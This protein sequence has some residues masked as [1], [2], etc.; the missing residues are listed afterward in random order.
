MDKKTFVFGLIIIIALVAMVFYYNNKNENLADQ[1]AS[2]LESVNLEKEL[3]NEFFLGSPEAPVTMVEYYSHLCGH[4]SSFNSETLPLIIEKYVK[5]GQVRI[6]PRP[7]SPYQLSLA[8]ICAQEQG[9]FFEFND[10]L[11]EKVS[12]IN[13]ID[14]IKEMA[15]QLGLNQENFDQCYDEE[16][17]AQEA[18]DWF[19]KAEEDN[20]E[21]VPHFIVN[22]QHISGNQTYTEFERVIEE[23]LNK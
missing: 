21:G 3:N 23:E 4:C 16:R 11:F 14:A 17:Y 1:S 7:V 18:K 5:T 2:I 8:L 9:K 15:G 12:E 10:Y 19:D 22:G 20:I 6:I 13:S